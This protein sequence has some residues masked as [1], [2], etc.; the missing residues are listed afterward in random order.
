MTEGER[1][2]ATI[3]SDT[4][5]FKGMSTVR[6]EP[7]RPAHVSWHLRCTPAPRVRGVWSWG[8]GVCARGVVD[9]MKGRPTPVALWV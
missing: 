2:V 4:F 9:P 5:A 8:V 1:L 3:K 7:P 6:H